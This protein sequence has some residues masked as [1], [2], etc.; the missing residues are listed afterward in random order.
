MRSLCWFG[1]FC[2]ITVS[3]EWI[4]IQCDFACWF[5]SSTPHRNFVFRRLTTHTFAY[6]LNTCLFQLYLLIPVL[7][8]PYYP[9]FYIMQNMFLFR[10]GLSFVIR[11][12][13]NR[14][15]HQN[16]A[17]RWLTTCTFA[18]LLNICLFQLYLLIPVLDFPNYPCIL[19]L[20]ELVL[21]SMRSVICH[22][23]KFY[24]FDKELKL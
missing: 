11:W 21:I 12:D 2:P 24:K 20:A 19:H 16:F 22:R 1:W 7:D 14:T 23:Q 3:K 6:L 5:Q 10:C 8:F 17:Y 9:A 13:F 18:Y 4:G 15:P